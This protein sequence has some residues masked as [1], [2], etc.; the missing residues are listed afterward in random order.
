MMTNTNILNGS[1]ALRSRRIGNLECVASCV[2]SPASH[3]IQMWGLDCIGSFTCNIV[4]L[5]LGC[6]VYNFKFYS[7][8]SQLHCN[9]PGNIYLDVEWGYISL[10]AV[11]MFRVISVFLS[12]VSRCKFKIWCFFSLLCEVNLKKT[13]LKHSCFVFVYCCVVLFDILVPFTCQT[14]T[15]G[16]KALHMSK[17]FNS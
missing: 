9:I 14:D 8:A 10:I 16:H 4:W 7:T 15:P 3:C 13:N 5:T 12:P 17:C 6:T 1:G 11:Y 2:Y